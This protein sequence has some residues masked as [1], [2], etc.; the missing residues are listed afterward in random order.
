M[1]G[2]ANSLVAEK[3]I[4]PFWEAILLSSSER[5]CTDG[6][7]SWGTLAGVTLSSPYRPQVLADASVRILS[8]L[9]WF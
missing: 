2:L 8:G 7:G 6:S 5:R 4:V 1:K 9:E 3:D